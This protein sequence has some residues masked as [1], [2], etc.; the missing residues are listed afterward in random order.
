MDLGA[1]TSGQS[2]GPGITAPSV[3][4]NLNATPA[5][6]SQLDLT[7]NASIENVGVVGCHVYRDGVEIDTTTFTSY[8][9]TGLN[10]GTEYTYRITVYDATGNESAQSSASATTD[11]SSHCPGSED[12]SGGCFIATAAMGPISYLNENSLS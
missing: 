6:H 10:S 3:P 8:T 2:S 12:G 9:D 7:W 11:S 5:S 4:Q 1:F